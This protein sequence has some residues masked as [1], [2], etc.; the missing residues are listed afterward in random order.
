MNIMLH[1]G[2][3]FALQKHAPEQ[4]SGPEDHEAGTEVELAL[5]SGPQ[6]SVGAGLVF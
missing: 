4:V 1:L 5:K 3:K 2:Y 6:V